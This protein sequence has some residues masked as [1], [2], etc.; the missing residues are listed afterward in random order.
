[1]DKMKTSKSSYTTKL[2]QENGVYN[3]YLN[4]GSQ[5]EQLNLDSGCTQTVF[6]KPEQDATQGIGL[7]PVTQGTGSPSSGGPRQVQP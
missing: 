5:W 7:H 2:Y 3:F 6:P 4:T 1:M